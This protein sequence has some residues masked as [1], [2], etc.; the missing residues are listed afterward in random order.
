[1]SANPCAVQA[2]ISFSDESLFGADDVSV[3]LHLG[4]NAAEG[5]SRHAQHLGH[6]GD[7]GDVVVCIKVF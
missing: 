4:E 6:E 7:V 2:A 1:M 5:G 3:G